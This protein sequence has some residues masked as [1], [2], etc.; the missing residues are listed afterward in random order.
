MKTYKLALP[1]LAAGLLCLLGTGCLFR[2]AAVTTRQFVLTPIQAAGQ[3]ARRNQP[4]IGIGPIKM[5]D[6]LLRS[7]MVVR[8]SDNE[9]EY[10]ENALWAE[11]LD[12]SFQRTMAANLVAQLPGSRIQ[13][14][15]WRSGEVAL[16]ASVSVERLDVDAQ[17]KGVLIARWQ[18]ESVTAP[19]VLKN[20]D[21]TLNKSGP[22]PYANPGAVATTLSDLT[23][24][25]S[26]VLAQALRECASEG[27]GTR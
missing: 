17:G 9:I 26:E 16:V 8:M 19:Q 13:L 2:P 22:V 20:G 12:R 5:P 24:Q 25:F 21:C 3:P 10:L 23:A 27:P 6:Y 4:A 11:R 1:F 14:S 7:S 18:I 15:A